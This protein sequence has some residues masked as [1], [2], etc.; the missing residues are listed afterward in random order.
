MTQ[1]PL[2]DKFGL[3]ALANQD[4]NVVG[5][6]FLRQA[7]LRQTPFF[8]DIVQSFQ[9]LLHH[10]RRGAIVAMGLDDDHPGPDPH[11]W[12]DQALRPFAIEL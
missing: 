6:A 2:V 12:Q 5:F 3:L 11:I 7:R 4:S 10:P 1:A 8:N 9:D